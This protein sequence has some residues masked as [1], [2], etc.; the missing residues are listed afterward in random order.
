MRP[1][2]LYDGRFW[3]LFTGTVLGSAAVTSLAVGPFATGDVTAIEQLWLASRLTIFGI[4]VGMITGLA[5]ALLVWALLWRGLTGWRL[6]ERTRAIFG[7]VVVALTVPSML[8]AL[9]WLVTP[10]EPYAGLALVFVLFGL[11]AALI[12]APALAAWIY[13]DAM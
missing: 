1:A 9:N 2:R 12:V 10:L 5:P 8:L 4:F 7:A 11:P 6:Q 3:R 13:K